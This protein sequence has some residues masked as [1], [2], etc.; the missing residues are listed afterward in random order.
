MIT[1]VT[2][3]KFFTWQQSLKPAQAQFLFSDVSLAPVL[4]RLVHNLM[5]LISHRREEGQLS[6]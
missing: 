6:L 5:E 3:T 2:A 4:E 1:P